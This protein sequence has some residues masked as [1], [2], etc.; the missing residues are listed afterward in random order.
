M[1]AYEGEA[2]DEVGTLD[3]LAGVNGGAVMISARQ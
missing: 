1:R 3:D 2:I